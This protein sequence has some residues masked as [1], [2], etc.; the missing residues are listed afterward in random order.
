MKLQRGTWLKL[1][2]QLHKSRP[3]NSRQLSNDRVKSAIMLCVRAAKVAQWQEQPSSWVFLKR[4]PKTQNEN[5]KRKQKTKTQNENKKRKHKTKTQNE[6][7]K[8]KRK[9]KTQN[10]NTKR[11]HKAKTQNENTKRKHKAKT[12]NENVRKIDGIF[13]HQK[14]ILKL[15]ERDPTMI[16]LGPFNDL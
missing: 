6:N 15:L 12:Q 14:P 3:Q 4:K 9:T 10:E 8:R 5:T 13:L 7:T 2:H 11:K 16:L 1:S